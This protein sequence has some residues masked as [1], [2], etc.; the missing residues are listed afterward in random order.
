MADAIVSFVVQEGSSPEASRPPS[1]SGTVVQYATDRGVVFQTD[2]SNL[3]W[4]CDL[5]QELNITFQENPLHFE[6]DTAITGEITLRDNIGAPNG[7]YY[8]CDVDVYGYDDGSVTAGAALGFD[9]YAE[10]DGSLVSGNHYTA[11]ILKNKQFRLTARIKFYANA[12]ETFRLF[13]TVQDTDFDE[14]YISGGICEVR[15]AYYID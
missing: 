9:L 7:T 15:R 10:V 2:N 3:L 13:A 4:Y 12:G 14:V 5:P 8:Y 1:P 11:V 6:T